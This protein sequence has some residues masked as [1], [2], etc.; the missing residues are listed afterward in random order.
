MRFNVLRTGKRGR[1]WRALWLLAPMSCFVAVLCLTR[2]EVRAD[3]PRGRHPTVIV[4]Q[5]LSQLQPWEPG[6][7]EVVAT[8]ESEFLSLVAQYSQDPD[9]VGT[10]VVTNGPAPGGTWPPCDKGMVHQWLCF[11]DLA[12][13]E[14]VWLPQMSVGWTP[15]YAEGLEADPPPTIA[16]AV[17]TLRLWNREDG[18]HG[19]INERTTLMRVAKAD[20]AIGVVESLVQGRDPISIGRLRAPDCDAGPWWDPLP[21]GGKH[22]CCE[23]QKFFCNTLCGWLRLL[24]SGYCDTCAQ[25]CDDC[26]VSNAC[27]SCG[28]CGLSWLLCRF[29]PGGNC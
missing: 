26:A 1:V 27:H 3:S 2:H 8:T 21:L 10:I 11:N 5:P 6:A 7:N 24:G 13:Y 23:S 28:W 25:D 16:E 29:I 18:G 9:F 4:Y 22:P 17:F 15:G 14:N 20:G 19:Y 12:Y